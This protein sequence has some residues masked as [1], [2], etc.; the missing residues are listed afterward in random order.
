MEIKQT[1][2]LDC[3]KNFK[4]N[5]TD[6]DFYNRLEV[7]PP[8]RCY[9]CRH[10]RR[11]ANRNERY[12]YHRTCDL[13]K[14]TIIS[15]ISEEKP[16]K[17]YDIDVWWSDSWD[18]LS[19]GKNF[20]FNHPFFEQFFELKKKVPRLALQQQRPMVNSDYCNCASQNK[21]CYLVFSTNRCEDCYYG[22]WI[23]DCKDCL[24]NLNLSN[25]ELCYECVSLN[26]CYKLLYSYD[27]INC[28][29]SFFLRNCIGCS[30]CF[31]CTNQHQKK[32]MIFNKQKTKEEY[33]TFLKN[34]AI[35]SFKMIEEIQKKLDGF[36][37]DLVVKE[38][39]GT[40]VENSIGDYLQN[41]KNAYMSFECSNCED[42]RYCLR[43]EEVKDSMDYSHWGKKAE[44]MY[45]CQAC[46]YDVFH[47]RFCNLCWSGCSNLTLSDHCFSCQNCF[48]CVGLKKKS[49]CILNKQ[50]SRQEYE[51]LVPRI[52]E[53]MRSNKEWGEFFE[54]AFSTFAYN[55]TISQEEF[56]LTKEKIIKKGGL[57]KD[58]LPYTTQKETI[59]TEK[60]PDTIKNVPQSIISEILDCIEC[61]K[62]YKI[63]PQELIFY[64][65]LEIPLPRR[66]PDCRHFKRRKLRNGKIIYDRNCAKC[67]KEIKTTYSP[68][69]K[70]IVYCETCYLQMV[71]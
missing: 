34:A 56:P 26:N 33:E 68:N 31:G 15:S 60:I 10:A 6:I 47:L 59:T 8:T 4:I 17:I 70:E 40:N 69:Q 65:K 38:F 52:I 35:N 39:H 24:D 42:V 41:T 20:D 28:R 46:G 7:P 44:L 54:I 2:C 29:D 5:Q 1:L 71:F 13:T 30:D 48:G 51:R 45:E 14:K 25:C 50:Y 22:S 64:K 61:T 19:Y 63:I 43:V 67:G 32:Y 58:D 57:W 9:L 27:C 11:L 21:N 18:A 23:N 55:E 16:F 3:E 53:H 12:L 37:N 36:L 49:Y 66:C 62:N